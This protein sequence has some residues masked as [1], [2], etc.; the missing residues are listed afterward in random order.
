MGEAI[1]LF[2]S[3]ITSPVRRCDKPY[4]CGTAVNTL[5]EAFVVAFTIKERNTLG[6]VSS[7]AGTANSPSRD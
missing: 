2:C 6:A 5:I 1:L 4:V 7:N 3:V